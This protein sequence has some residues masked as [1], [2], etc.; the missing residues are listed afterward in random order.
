[1]ILH[2]LGSIFL[3]GGASDLGSLI[4]TVNVTGGPKHTIQQDLSERARTRL[5]LWRIGL[6]LLFVASVA[7]FIL[8]EKAS[9]IKG[10]WY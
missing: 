8:I 3:L 6:F 1:M 7:A 4:Y 9:G 2:I 5:V 10:K